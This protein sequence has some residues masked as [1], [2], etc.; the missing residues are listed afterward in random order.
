MSSDAAQPSPPPLSSFLGGWVRQPADAPT[1][2]GAD[3]GTSGSTQASAGPAAVP[4]PAAPP[5]PAPPPSPESPGSPGASAPMAAPAPSPESPDE[6]ARS[7]VD[8]EHIIE[9]A[10]PRD[11]ADDAGPQYEDEDFDEIADEP[12]GPGLSASAETV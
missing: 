8:E 10:D 9:P 3:P 2:Q 6:P 12:P 1:T 11:F 5:A 4:P 7:E